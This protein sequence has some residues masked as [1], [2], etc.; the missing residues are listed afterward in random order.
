MNVQ[1]LVSVLEMNANASLRFVLPTGELVPDHFHVTE[2]GRIEKNFIDCGGT[3]RQSV[4]CMLQAWAADD[5]DHRLTAGKLA[6]IFQL[7]APILKTKDL[8]VEVEYGTEVAGQYMLDRVET[9]DMALQFVLVAK[10]TDCLARDKC[11]VDECSA[12]GCCN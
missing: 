10:H 9:T 11:G 3:R 4:S 6:K 5:V 1:E 8:P 12:V 7:A 2:I